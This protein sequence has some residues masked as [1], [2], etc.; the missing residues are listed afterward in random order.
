[1]GFNPLKIFKKRN[2]EVIDLGKL[3]QNVGTSNVENTETQPQQTTETGL[4][5]IGN[6]ASAS[7]SKE[8][9][10]NSNID[11]DRFDRFGKRIDRLLGRM[12]L[13]ERKIERVE[14]RLD[15]S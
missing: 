11:V 13:L 15:I 3:H 14:H 12:E 1:M 2:D 4:G 10:T 6:L 5:F 7:D 8:I 9:K